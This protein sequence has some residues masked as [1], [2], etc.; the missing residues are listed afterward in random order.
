MAGFARMAVEWKKE[1]DMRFWNQERERLKSIVSRERENK[2][3][4]F[5]KLILLLVQLD[6]LAK[7][8]NKIRRLEETQE[9]L[10]A[11]FRESVLGLFGLVPLSG[12][13][14]VYV[15]LNRNVSHKLDTHAIRL[16][17]FKL[18]L[19]RDDFALNFERLSKRCGYGSWTRERIITEL[20]E[21]K[22]FLSF[23][24]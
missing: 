3:N 12:N 22:D 10:D 5:V 14:G 19:K 23:E 21:V 13:F 17:K 8:E 2:S 18:K 9:E 16:L 6:V 20:A 7:E 4:V 15:K 11:T 1:E 24:L